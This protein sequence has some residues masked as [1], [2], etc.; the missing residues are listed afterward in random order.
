MLPSLARASNLRRYRRGDVLLEQGA[1]ATDVLLV[2]TGLLGTWVSK[3]DEEIRLELAGAGQ[4]LVFHET[5][6]SSPSA[7][8]IVAEK[9]TDVLAIPVSAMLAALDKAPMLA[10]DMSALAEARR[11][12][13]I[14]AQRGIRRVV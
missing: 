13:I 7:A 1:V 14:A 12:A 10:R 4:L 11:Q 3:N 2:A 9:D 8:R 5:L 6:A